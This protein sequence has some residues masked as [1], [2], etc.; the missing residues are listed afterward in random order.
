MI[1]HDALLRQGTMKKPTKTPKQAIAEERI[2][3]AEYEAADG[4]AKASAK[5]RL[6][7]AAKA[8]ASTT[9]AW[10]KYHGAES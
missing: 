3:K 6:D 8:K 10:E 4:A 7:K 5:S 9:K 2:A 1:P